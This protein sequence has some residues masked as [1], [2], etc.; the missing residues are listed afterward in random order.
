MST[1]SGD[2]KV[3]EF[4]FQKDMIRPSSGVTSEL[5]ELRGQVLRFALNAQNKA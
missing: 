5:R 2:G 4:T 3:N 1:L